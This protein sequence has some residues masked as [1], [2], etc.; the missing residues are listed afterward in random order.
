MNKQEIINYL[1]DLAD[2]I[3]ERG[4]GNNDVDYL[5]EIADSLQIESNIISDIVK[6]NKNRLLDKQDFKPEVEIINILEEL[7]EMTG[8]KSDSARRMSIVMYDLYFKNATYMGTELVDA[9]ADIIVF[10]TGALLK[11]GYDPEKVMNEVI[12]EI[13]S[14]TG[15]IING[16]FVKCKTP[17][18]Q[19]KWYKADFEKAKL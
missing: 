10:S 3:E 14:R 4:F 16:K 11:L 1:R 5:R 17:E 7:I 6:W 15:E 13:N 2:W 18:C 8:Y 12:K 19:A 9:F